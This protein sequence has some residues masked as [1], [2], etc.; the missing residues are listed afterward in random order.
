MPPS[1]GYVALLGSIWV[2]HV[3]AQNA[4]CIAKQP[5]G[6]VSPVYGFTEPFTPYLAPNGTTSFDDTDTSGVIKYN[7]QWTSTSNPRA[8]NSTLHVTDDTSA[9]VSFTFTGSGIEWFGATGQDQGVAKV[10]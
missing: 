1:Y 9:S 10:S 7:G 8:V 3:L 5:P 2:S 4:S 6:Y